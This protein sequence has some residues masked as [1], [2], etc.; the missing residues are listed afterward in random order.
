MVTDL[1]NVPP[2]R[3]APMVV[4]S[5]TE[6][7]SISYSVRRLTLQE[8]TDDGLALLVKH[9]LQRL[10]QG[11]RMVVFAGSIAKVIR[12]AELTQLPLY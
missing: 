5:S 12:I 11:Q 8:A 6:R 10:T 9:Y 7:A 3:N 1:M 4:R 2:P